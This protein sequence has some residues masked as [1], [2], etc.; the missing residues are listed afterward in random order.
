MVI[1]DYQFG[2]DGDICI[3]LRC[4]WTRR[5]P[6]SPVSIQKIECN[7][8]RTREPLWEPCRLP[9]A[10]IDALEREV[11][12]ELRDRELVDDEMEIE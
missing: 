5:R 3:D 10:V 6:G 11:T 12:A 2:P 7:N 9:D 1:D 8:S 4:H